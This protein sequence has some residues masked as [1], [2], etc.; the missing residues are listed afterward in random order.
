MTFPNTL[1][2]IGGGNMARSLIGGLTARGMPPAQIIVADPVASQLEALAAQY[3][4]RV[5]SDNAL[6]AAGADVAVLAIKP[7]QMRQA[8][9]AL[10]TTLPPHA[11]VVSVA[12]GILTDDLRSWCG[13]LPVVRCMPNRPALHGCGITA[14]YATADV[15]AGA[16]QVAQSI[17]SAVGTT[18]WVDHEAHLDAVTALSGSGPAYFFF[19]AEILEH[20]GVAL[21]LSPEVSR[22]L[23]TATAHGAGCMLREAQETPARL[24][25][26]VTSK[27]GTTEAALEHLEANNVR[28]IFAAAVTAAARRSA[29]LAQEYGER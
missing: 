11:L 24:R 22:Q 21:G 9:T 4:V 7:Q 15:S 28:A 12:A 1:A 23:A 17:L 5:T 20:T 10:A 2:F 29:A 26:Q 13:G 16:R 8:A 14:L 27:A 6:A 25:E 18:L 19:L 3:A